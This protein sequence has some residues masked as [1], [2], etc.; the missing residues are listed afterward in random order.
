[1]RCGKCGQE[2]FHGLCKDCARKPVIELAKEI[3]AADEERDRIGYTPKDRWK[4]IVNMAYR[5]QGNY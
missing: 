5:I 3:I 1:M 2:A 4:N